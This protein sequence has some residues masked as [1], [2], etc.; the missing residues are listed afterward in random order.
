MSRRRSRSQNKKEKIDPELVKRVEAQLIFKKQ[1][2]IVDK[3][4][5]RL[6]VSSQDAGFINASHLFE[7]YSANFNR[8]SSGLITA[9]NSKLDV[10][11]HLVSLDNK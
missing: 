10:L 5:G 9:S 7:G 6:V 4:L 11:M 3:I 1:L 8:I 2:E